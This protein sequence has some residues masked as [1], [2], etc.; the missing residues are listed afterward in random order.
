M[1]F[2]KGSA[3]SPS[4]ALH[5][6]TSALECTPVMA[7]LRQAKFNPILWLACRAARHSSRAV[8]AEHV[9][10]RLEPAGRSPC[11]CSLGVSFISR[12]ARLALE[13]SDFLSFLTHVMG[14]SE[15]G[16]SEVGFAASDAPAP[17]GPCAAACRAPTVRK[18]DKPNARIETL[19]K[20]P[21]LTTASRG[22]CRRRQRSRIRAR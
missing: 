4:A 3:F 6:E 17:A 19:R 2:I 16:V 21:F 7:A 15:W 5:S 10:V 11:A 1:A 8:N 22:F 9:P 14:L 12:S 13:S 20:F 18:A